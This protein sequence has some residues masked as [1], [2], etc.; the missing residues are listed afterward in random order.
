MFGPK[1]LFVLLLYL[2]CGVIGSSILII[3]MITIIMIMI[4]I[5]MIYN[6]K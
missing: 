3:V 1:L 6:R 4:M 5:L 2:T